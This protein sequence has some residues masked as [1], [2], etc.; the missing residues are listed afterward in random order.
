[1][2]LKKYP[3]SADGLLD[4]APS[5]ATQGVTGVF[6]QIPYLLEM[7][8]KRLMTATA[9]AVAATLTHADPI[10]HPPGPNLTYGAVSNGQTIMSD[11]TNPA[12]GAAVL[13]KEG[14]QYRFGILSSIGVG[15]EFGQV[16]GLF[17]SLDQ[18]AN[19][20][21][22]NGVSINNLADVANSVNDQVNAI[23]SI[24]R[25]IEDKGYAKIFGSAHLPIMPLV[26]AHKALGGSIV[27]D[28]NGSV[29]AKV[30]ALQDD[31]LFDANLYDPLGPAVQTIGDVTID[32]NQ[33][34]LQVDNDTTLVA[35]AAKTV[36]LAMGYSRP[37]FKTDDAMLYG[38]LRG[39][40]Y[41]VELGR[42]TTRLGDLSS[43]SQDVFDNATDVTFS[44]DTGFGLDA[45]VL[46]VSKHYRAG[47]TLTNINEPSFDYG[48]LDLSA[49]DMSRSVGQRL[50]AGETYTMEKQLQ[51]EAALFTENQN[52]VISAGFDANAVKDALGDEYQWATVSAAYATD[53]WWLPGLRAG[54]RKNMAGTEIDYLSV[55]ATLAMVNID[56]AWSSDKVTIEGNTVPRGAMINLGLEV[57]F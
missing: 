43:G 18:Q 7:M 24:L 53:T 50:A 56:V 45:G 47:A 30:L 11:I 28:V 41:K 38:G 37:I 6:A 27:L 3:I 15:V 13:E 1:V 40:Y 10:Y 19:A 33:G 34:T 31:I 32:T 46:W 16:D 44:S 23:N 39:R 51:L 52:W 20:F 9:L 36:E 49:Y 2:A 12:A 42:T 29:E 55:G 54:L 5:H 26:V 14:N 57:S 8:M 17:E 4:Y 48:P 21:D 22:L 25:E 35:K